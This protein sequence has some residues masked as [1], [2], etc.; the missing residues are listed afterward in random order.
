MSCSKFSTPTPFAEIHACGIDMMQAVPTIKTRHGHGFKR[1]TDAFSI[2]DTAGNTTYWLLQ[3]FDT[4]NKKNEVKTANAYLWRAL[5]GG[6]KI[7]SFTTTPDAYSMDDGRVLSLITC[8][9]AKEEM[10]DKPKSLAACLYT[11]NSLAALSSFSLTHDEK[12]PSCLEFFFNVIA[13]TRF[14]LTHI[15]SMEDKDIVEL[16][17]TAPRMDSDTLLD[18][19]E[20]KCNE[21]RFKQRAPEGLSDDERKQFEKDALSE[22]RAYMAT[23]KPRRVVSCCIRWLE[24]NLRLPKTTDPVVCKEK[25]GQKIPIAPEKIAQWNTT[26][27]LAMIVI[28]SNMYKNSPVDLQNALPAGFGAWVAEFTPKDQRY[29][30]TADKMDLDE[31]CKTAK[32]KI[33]LMKLLVTE[34]A[35]QEAFIADL[36]AVLESPGNDESARARAALIKLTEGI[37]DYGTSI[38]GLARSILL[39]VITGEIKISCPLYSEILLFFRKIG[40]NWALEHI[41]VYQ[42]DEND[43]FDPFMLLHLS[44][45]STHPMRSEEAR[46]SGVKRSLSE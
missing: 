10:F 39:R 35:R 41:T 26:V 8:P 5:D 37:H 3:Y 34:H 46:F 23:L 6:V 15:M 9:V 12:D 31:A 36:K 45:E 16:L 21:L 42:N 29:G 14:A 28:G 20:D 19:L 17:M 38:H 25:V 44:G 33:S 2:S 18:M 43:A 32:G 4:P 30:I 24:N 40:L 11:T 7:E 27:G 22:A 1:T 13:K